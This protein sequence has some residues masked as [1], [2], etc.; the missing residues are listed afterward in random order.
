VEMNGHLNAQSV[1][2]GHGA[3][4]T[5]EI[6]LTLAANPSTDQPAS[7]VRTT[8]PTLPVPSS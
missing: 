3:V 7:E 5:L 8:L 4:F 6:P 2:P 1:G